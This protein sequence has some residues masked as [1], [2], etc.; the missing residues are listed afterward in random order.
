MEVYQSDVMFVNGNG[1][2]MSNDDSNPSTTNVKNWATCFV[3]Y[4]NLH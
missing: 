1:L 3:F 2:R 4:R